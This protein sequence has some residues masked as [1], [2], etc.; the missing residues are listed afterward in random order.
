MRTIRNTHEV[1]P[2]EIESI[3]DTIISVR[4]SGVMKVSDQ[5]RLQSFARDLIGQGK[6]VRVL[7]KLEN[8]QGWEK[9]EQWD[10]IN[11]LIEHGNAIVK[12]AIVGDERWKDEV[13]LF[14]GKGFRT[15]EIAFFSPSALTDA[16][17][18]VRG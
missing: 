1:M 8:F 12:M 7:A 6:E 18:W 10:D 5:A 3:D 4:I 9:S 11:F 13:F 2:H 16:E 15:T 14:A 17:A